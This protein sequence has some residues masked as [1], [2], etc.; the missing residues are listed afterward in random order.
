MN[1]TKINVYKK[2]LQ[3]LCE[4]FNG[5]EGYIKKRIEGLFSE[6]KFSMEEATYLFMN[7]YNNF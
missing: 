1:N 2:V 7:D 3:E 6:D 4:K 5:A